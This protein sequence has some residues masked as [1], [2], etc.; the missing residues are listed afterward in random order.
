MWSWILE[1]SDNISRTH[2]ELQL[3]LQI[4]ADST[5]VEEAIALISGVALHQDSSST[6]IWFQRIIIIITT[7]TRENWWNPIFFPSF[8]FPTAH[9]ATQDG[10]EGKVAHFIEEGKKS[11]KEIN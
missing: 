10:M 5:A 4:L 9:C 1:E 2:E 7:N 6:T 3:G 11:I 8:F